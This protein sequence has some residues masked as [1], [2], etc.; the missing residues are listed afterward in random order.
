MI[1][2]SNT[3]SPGEGLWPWPVVVGASQLMGHGALGPELVASESL[4]R[5]PRPWRELGTPGGLP[6]GRERLNSGR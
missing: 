1:D 2:I 4:P 5:D 6:E 3:A